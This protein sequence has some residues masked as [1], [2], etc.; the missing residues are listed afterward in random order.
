MDNAHFLFEY[1][2]ETRAYRPLGQFDERHDVFET[3]I[4]FVHDNERCVWLSHS[5]NIAA[6]A[7]T[8]NTKVTMANSGP[9]REFV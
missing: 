6:D 1:D 5:R 9:H 4:V 3:G 7:R 8:T 2:V